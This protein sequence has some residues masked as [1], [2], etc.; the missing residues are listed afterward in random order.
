[1]GGTVDLINGESD[2]GAGAKAANS[3]HELKHLGRPVVNN[4]HIEPNGSLIVTSLTVPLTGL[5][6]MF[7]SAIFVDYDSPS[8]RQ[9]KY[10]DRPVPQASAGAVHPV[11]RSRVDTTG[12][13]AVGAGE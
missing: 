4:G 2:R 3:A 10:F 7:A 5:R 6:D 12:S 13:S 1:M 8:S 9:P 11:Q